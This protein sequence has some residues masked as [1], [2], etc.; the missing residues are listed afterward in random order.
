MTKYPRFESTMAHKS[1]VGVDIKPIEEIKL[2]SGLDALIFTDGSALCSDG[3]VIKNFIEFQ[4]S[5]QKNF[6]NARKNSRV[7]YS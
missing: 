1:L 6:I 5:F 4:K 7:R 3:C 2:A